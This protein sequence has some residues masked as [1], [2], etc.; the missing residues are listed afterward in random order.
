MNRDHRI[1]RLG[2]GALAAALLAL[3]S[4]PWWLGGGQQSMMIEFA[5]FLALAQMWNL[6]AGYAGIVSL[7]QQAFIGLGGYI[8]YALVVLCDVPPMLALALAGIAGA[9]IAAP[10]ALL[11]F[12]LHGP[13]LAIGTWVVAEVF[14]LGIS[15]ITELGAGS[16]M[17]LPIEVAD[18]L[19]M[20]PLGRDGVLYLL[21][22]SLALAAN[23]GAIG[24]LRSPIGLALT[25]IRDNEQAAASAGVDCRRVKLLVYLATALGTSLVGALIFLTK[26]RISPA[27]AFDINWTSYAIFI[28][29]IGGLG[30][31]EGPIVG[32]I[33]F[34]LLREFLAD[35]GTWYLII[36]GALAVAVML[37][38]PN[39]VWGSLA[40]RY[41]LNLFATG[42]RLDV[43]E[44][45]FE[46]PTKRSVIRSP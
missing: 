16:G 39:G 17:S 25:A 26:F 7:G 15:Q 23:F 38:A 2:A 1:S 41:G 34:F 8:L 33:I 13:H 44:L 29:V 35:L 28:V 11:V 36:L 27:A 20:A 9:L 42:R 31:L 4:G 6:L 43:T 46:P 3:A 19:D 45:E 37:R 5:C 14:A 32:T 21:A 30:T 24:L 22:V 12:R 40:K 18:A 10:V